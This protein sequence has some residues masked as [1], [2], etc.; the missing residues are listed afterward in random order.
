MEFRHASP[1]Q[2][3]SIAAPKPA[4]PPS[5]PPYHIVRFGLGRPAPAGDLA[6]LHTRLLPTSPACRLGRRFLREFYYGVLPAEGHLFGTVAYY[7]GQ[8]IGLAVGAPR[9][10]GFIGAAA[11]KRPLTLAK[12]LGLEVIRRPGVLRSLVQAVRIARIPHRSSPSMGQFLTL[13]VEREY[14]SRAFKEETGL[15]VGRDLAEGLM[16]TFVEAGVMHTRA[17]VDAN[18]AGAIARYKRRGLEPTRA[19]VP[20][21]PVPCLEFILTPADYKYEA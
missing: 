19:I 5:A 13:A 7:G 17:Y 6:E 18:N 14:R 2:A 11:R 1:P 16:A 8:P 4:A 3:N 10:D 21:W 20:G 12:I 9:C 15:R